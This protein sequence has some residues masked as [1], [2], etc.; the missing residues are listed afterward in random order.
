MAGC[1]Q[2]VREPIVEPERVSNLALVRLRHQPWVLVLGQ[3]LFTLWDPHLSSILSAYFEPGTVLSVL[4]PAG[5]TIAWTKNRYYFSLKE[6]RE[7]QRWKMVCEWCQGTGILGKPDAKWLF[8]VFMQIIMRIIMKLDTCVFAV[9]SCC[10]QLVETHCVSQKEQFYVMKY[11]ALLKMIC[12]LKRIAIMLSS[13][14]N[15]E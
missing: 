4:P 2:A 8:F 3:N 5:Y 15:R 6:I 7:L 10:T 13:E 11:N 12:Q 9:L 1:S 14:L